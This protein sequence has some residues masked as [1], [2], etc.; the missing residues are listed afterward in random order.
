MYLS[1]TCSD[2]QFGPISTIL[3]I[4][5]ALVS[6]SIEFISQALGESGMFV[7]LGAFTMFQTI[8][9]M[10]CLKETADLTDKEKKEL[11]WPVDKSD[12]KK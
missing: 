7:L 4:N 12:P 5:G 9:N 8:F 3:Y 10:L 11:Y 1:E 6:V 2:A